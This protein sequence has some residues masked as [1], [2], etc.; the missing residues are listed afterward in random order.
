MKVKEKVNQ[1]GKFLMAGGSVYIFRLVSIYVF[2]D[3]LNLPFHHIY[4]I[5]LIALFFIGFLLNFK[6]VFTNSSDVKRKM[7]LF[8]VTNLSLNGLDY[9][10]VFCLTK[11]L[12]FEKYVS[13]IT[14]SLIIFV[15]KFFAL[16]YLV[17]VENSAHNTS[18]N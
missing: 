17:F 14:I 11:K 6:F 2:V 5:V 8:L 1:I 16:K 7:F 9:S 10:L 4:F 15:M 18:K 13:V 3:R 12:H